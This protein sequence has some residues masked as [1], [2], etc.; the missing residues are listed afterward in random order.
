MT[1]HK[2]HGLIDVPA[3]DV[4]VLPEPLQRHVCVRV[5][6][7]QL[8]LFGVHHVVHVSELLLQHWH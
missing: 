4:F 3:E 8:L 5:A 1:H 2:H 6:S 7:P